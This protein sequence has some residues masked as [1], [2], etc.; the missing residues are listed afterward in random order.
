MAPTGSDAALGAVSAASM[1][2]HL[3]AP[4]G[5]NLVIIYNPRS[6]HEPDSPNTNPRRKAEG[7]SVWNC[8]YGCAMSRKMEEGEV[9]G[10]AEGET[11]D[12][13]RLKVKAEGEVDG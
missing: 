13:V 6:A 3:F 11:E 12:E 7:I 8:A 9:G 2:L 1:L 5:T 4:G 10:E